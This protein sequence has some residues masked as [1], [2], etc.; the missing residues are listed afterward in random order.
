MRRT[1]QSLLLVVVCLGM[2]SLTGSTALGQGVQ[3]GTLTG[4][5]KLPDGSGLPG[6]SVTVSSPALQGTRTQVTGSAGDYVF[7]FLPPG[8]YK[9]DFEISGMK[10]VTRYATLAV[11]GSA[12]ADATMTPSATAEVTVLGAAEDVDKTTVHSST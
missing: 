2:L 3:T 7:K 11:G 9:V 1:G 8:D 10:T 6:A 4:T 12:V 5:V